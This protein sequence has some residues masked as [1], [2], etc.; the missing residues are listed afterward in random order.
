MRDDRAG[1]TVRHTLY[2]VCL[3]V[4]TVEYIYAHIAV[5]FCMKTA[6][7]SNIIIYIVST[8]IY[9]II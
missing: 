3:G 9:N 7:I 1:A 8:Q 4:M 5:H 2:K 6:N